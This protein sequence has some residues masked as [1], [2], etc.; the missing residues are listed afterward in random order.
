M[1]AQETPPERARQPSPLGDDV[2]PESQE[3]AQASAQ[4]VSQTT[5]QQGLDGA[6]D[7]A[8]PPK[9]SWSRRAFLG[10]ALG[11]AA[12]IAAAACG[13][14]DPTP[15]PTISPLAASPLNTPGA[16]PLSTAAYQNYLPY[17]ARDAINPEGVAMLPP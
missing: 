8:L 2:T 1:N 11:S 12:A 16:R 9:R 6:P 14:S 15:T 5:A 17:V 13:G 4:A 3:A 10:S 7:E